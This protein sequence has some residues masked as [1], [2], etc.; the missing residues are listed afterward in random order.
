MIMKHGSAFLLFFLLVGVLSPEV[1]AQE[2]D[3]NE[4]PR[5]VGCDWATVKLATD[6]CNFITLKHAGLDTVILGIN[7]GW[8]G[9]QRPL[10]GRRVKGLP[11]DKPC[12]WDGKDKYNP[13]E[14]QE[15]LQVARQ[16]HPQA[17]IILW[18][19]IDT[20]PEWVQENPTEILRN[21]K[22]DGFAVTY[23]FK[24]A[25]NNPNPDKWE[26]LAWSF[27]SQKLREDLAKM[28]TQFVKAVESSPGGDQVVG[29]L[30]G[31]AQD[32]QFYL[33]EAP[34]SSKVNDQALWSDYSQP[35]VAAWHKWLRKKY[36]DPATLSK[37][38][39]EP[40]ASFE[41]AAPPKAATLIGTE[42]FHDP[43][44]ERRQMDWK[45]FIADGR[46]DLAEDIADMIRSASSHKLLIG[47]SSGD[48]GSRANMTANVRLMHSKKLD[49]FNGPVRYSLRLPPNSVGG[50]LIPYDSFRLN[51]KPIAFD[52]D[53]RT[54]KDKKYGDR[55]VA[56]GYNMNFRA[57][58]QAMT[59]EELS[60][61]WLREAGRIVLGGHRAF[62]DPVEGAFVHDDPLIQLEMN[63]L[64]KNLIGTAALPGEATGA[65]VAVIYDERSADFL[66]GNLATV[67]STWSS[68]QRAEL[69][70]SGVPYGYYY[71]EDFKAGKVPPAKLYI[72]QNLLD[73]DS[74]L[75]SAIAKVRKDN[76]VLCFLQGTGY[77]LQKTEPERLSRIIGMNVVPAGAASTGA[78]QVLPGL[79]SLLPLKAAPA[80]SLPT[81]WTAFGP[82]P[83]K[84]PAVS[85]NELLS[86]PERIELSGSVYPAQ[87]IIRDGGLLDFGKLF[88]TKGGGQS[89]YAFCQIHSDED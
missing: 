55:K 77:N 89:A 36:A 23:H 26:V 14:I 27:Y 75:E 54:W 86:I 59:R 29:Y 37:A 53:Y 69:D 22:G 51:N 9:G 3:F 6:K 71:V 83:D 76:A 88:S 11:V 60:S 1:S 17:K 13:V 24:R 78:T 62:L 10:L 73:I 74:Q 28:L 44:T 30:I 16:Q 58:G 34:N 67:H 35:A 81:E 63:A 85:V 18:I 20:Y 56:P 64:Q 2:P 31:G 52:L 47:T 57:V 15:L 72:F 8:S 50:A 82:F 40:V 68:Y 43:V 25:G 41:E 5:I 80:I 21:E 19:Q 33:W 45:R 84:V 79:Q 48:N 4:L 39:N 61:A 46:V 49:F 65:E 42:G 12:F 7:A 32:A 70:L 38:W 87:R 66:K